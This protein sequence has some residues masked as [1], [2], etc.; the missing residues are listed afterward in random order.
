MST[1]MSLYCHS[2]LLKNRRKFA[3]IHKSLR[4]EKAEKLLKIKGFQA[5]C[6]DEGII[7]TM[8]PKPRRR[9]RFPYPAPYKKSTPLGVLF[10]ILRTDGNR[11]NQNAN[12]RWTFAKCQLDGT[13]SLRFAP[14][15]RQSIPVPCFPK[16]GLPKEK[17][18]CHTAMT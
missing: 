14:A 4:I 13:Y 11:T 3:K 12:V 1:K 17:R 7:V 5:F 2:I 18:H 10:C 8:L 15:N 9:V 6:G 16:C